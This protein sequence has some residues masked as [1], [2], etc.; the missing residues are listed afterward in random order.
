MQRT[1]RAN[2]LY[3]AR[4]T[5]VGSLDV[6]GRNILITNVIQYRV[7][8]RTQHLEGEGSGPHSRQL[9]WAWKIQTAEK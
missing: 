4:R 3:V 9:S 1:E 8:G 2:P 6:M 7:L 5:S